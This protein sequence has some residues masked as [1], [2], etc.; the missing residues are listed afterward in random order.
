MCLCGCA[1][2]NRS[3]VPHGL[4]ESALGGFVCMWQDGDPSREWETVEGFFSRIEEWCESA[5]HG[6]GRR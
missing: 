1:I 6:W 5:Q 4:K 3:S 2:G